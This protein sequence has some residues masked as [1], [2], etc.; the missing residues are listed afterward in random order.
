M[1]SPIPKKKKKQ[2]SS[3]FANHNLLNFRNFESVYN[4]CAAVYIAIV[5]FDHCHYDLVML[6][7]SLA[8]LSC[9]M[10]YVQRHCILLFLLFCS[11]AMGLGTSCGFTLAVRY[12]IFLV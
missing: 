5:Y 4:V 1:R 7:A 11:V 8:D 6:R 12:F 3:C 2:K 9:V 10:L